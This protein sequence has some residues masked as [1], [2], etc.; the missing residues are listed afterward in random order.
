MTGHAEIQAL[1]FLAFARHSVSP[2]QAPISGRYIVMAQRKLLVSALRRLP[3][4]TLLAVALV[5]PAGPA[6]ASPGCEAAAA[7]DLD[8]TWW[9]GTTNLDFDAG[10]TLTVHGVTF[11][12]NGTAQLRVNNVVVASDQFT[13]QS[14]TIVYTFPTATTDQ[15]LWS[16]LSGSSAGNIVWTLDCTPGPVSAESATWGNIKQLFR[17]E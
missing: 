14:T 9:A 10:N 6:V 1:K 8:T 7:G 17:D 3:A 11:S 5:A 13:N 12:I 2:D 15:I 16:T 4:L